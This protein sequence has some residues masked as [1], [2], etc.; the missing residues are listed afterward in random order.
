MGFAF[1]GGSEQHGISPIATVSAPD[2]LYANIA[3]YTQRIKFMHQIVLLPHKI[4]HPLRVAE[5]LATLDLVSDGRAILGV[6]RGNNPYQLEAFGVDAK[7]VRGEMMESLEVI[8]KALT[9][10]EFE[11]V[12]E[13]LT[14]PPWS[15]APRPLQDPHPPILM[16]G[17]SL[18]SNRYAGEMGIGIIN[19]DNWLGWDALQERVD[20]YQAAI[21]N[22]TRQIG[23]KVFNRMCNTV[24][25]A[26]CA[27]T[28]EEAKAL[29]G[30]IAMTFLGAITSLTYGKLAKES[31]DYAYMAKTG[32]ELAEII[33]NNDV[34]ALIERTPSILIGTPEDF[35]DRGKRLEA[36]GYDEVT[37]RI[38]GMGHEKTLRTLELIGR[39]V[40]P[41]FEAPNSIAKRAPL[42]G[43]IT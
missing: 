30:P 1:W 10:E 21:V 22:P 3:A 26:Y 37:L 27:E 12:G 28:R 4:N 40:I 33:E 20:A 31:P 19:F 36:M 35:I 8:G 5:R 23:G 15:L 24:I 13:K 34:D 41:E 32:E 42:G 6:G 18:E 11:H 17:T 2:V 7:D 29:A 25:T 16:V 14:I 39:H 9:Y 38:E 43:R